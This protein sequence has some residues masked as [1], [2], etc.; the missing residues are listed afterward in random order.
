[1]GYIS[2]YQAIGTKIQSGAASHR[3][4]DHKDGI[5]HV[6]VIVVFRTLC[7]VLGGSSYPLL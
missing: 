2:F 1:M 4:A 3:L 7:F 5:K 6:M